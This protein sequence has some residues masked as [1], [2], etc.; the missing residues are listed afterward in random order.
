MK[1]QLLL[2]VM[3]LSTAASAFAVEEV[4]IDGLWYEVVAKAKEAKV[5]QHKNNVKYNGDIV[6]PETVVYEGVTYSVTSIGDYAFWDCSDLTSVTIPNS[7]TSIGDRAFWDCSGLKKV[8]VKDIAAWC[9]ISFSDNPLSHSHHLYSDE[10]TEITELIIPNSVTSIG[11]YAFE[12]CYGLTS[13]TIG[14][15]VTSIGDA[16][17]C[18]CSGLTSVTIPNSVTSIENSAFSGCDDLKKVVVKDIAAWC[19]ISFSNTYS[20]PL[21]YA[22]RLYID[23]NTEITELIIPNSVE[24][25]GD[26]AFFN[27]S[28]LTSVTIGNSVTIIGMAAFFKCSGLTSVT[29]PNSVTSIERSAFSGCTGLTSVTIP[30]SVTYIGDYAFQN[31]SGLTSVA[32]GGGVKSI[33]S[34]AFANCEE[35]T[36]VTCYAKI[37]PSTESNVF[38]DSYI[39]YATLHV[40]TGAINAYKATEP[41][42]NFKKIVA[43]T[44]QELSVD[45]ITNDSNE[46][47]ARYTIG[48]QRANRQTKGLN[49]VRMSNGT[50]KKVVAK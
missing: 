17:F 32:I 19:R 39:E 15:C 49:I 22:H 8:I 18:G 31:C 12:Y 45:A 21:Y 23:E 34:G 36:D 1:K 26:R 20:N 4:E 42:K 14:N 13:V 41:W 43:L 46:A 27:C 37:I 7:V 16:A 30:N 10:N 6:I 5:I 44:D 33:R 11:E 38:N 48:G 3:L 35:L 28:G 29:I 40:P 9:G 24:S 50:S 2:I 25:I 47:V